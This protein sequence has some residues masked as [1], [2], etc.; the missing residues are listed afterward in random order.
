MFIRIIVRVIIIRV[1]AGMRW[2]VLGRQLVKFITT[3]VF[4]FSDDKVKNY[5]KGLCYYG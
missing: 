5:V 2:K 1:I 4:F 3:N